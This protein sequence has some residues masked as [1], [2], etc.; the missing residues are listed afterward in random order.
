MSKIYRGTSK[1]RESTGDPLAKLS[2]KERQEVFQM[3]LS[4]DVG[5]ACDRWLTERGLNFKAWG[6]RA[7]SDKGSETNSTNEP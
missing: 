5:K 4:K 7:D 1:S 3:R 6:T 2:T